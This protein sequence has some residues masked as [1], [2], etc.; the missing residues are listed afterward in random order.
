MATAKLTKRL[1]DSLQAPEAGEIWVW[2]AETKGFGLKVTPGG[3]KVFYL[4]FRTPTDRTTKKLTIGAFGAVTVEQA[5]DQAIKALGAIVA[6]SDPA[7]DRANRR[8]APL[9]AEAL[10]D[11]LNDHRGKWKPRTLAEY[12]RQV[13]DILTPALGT[14][15]VADLS[16]EDV[17][18]VIRRLSK[19]PTLANRVLACPTCSES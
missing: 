8:K 18:T 4:K 15:K 19:T 13:D 10:A 11:Y 17:A 12:T 2:D 5:R 7:R 6:G 3:R 16:R 1:I 9:M 14:T